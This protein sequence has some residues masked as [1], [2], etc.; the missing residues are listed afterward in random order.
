MNLNIRKDST[1]KCP[2]AITAHPRTD[3]SPGFRHQFV[4]GRLG[5][6]LSILQI[7][8]WRLFD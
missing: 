1:L 4:A 5:R 7:S 3:V 6:Q 8:R 2:N